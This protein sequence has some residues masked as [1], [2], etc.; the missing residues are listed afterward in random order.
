[1][2]T[3]LSVTLLGVC[4][5]VVTGIIV[6]RDL[7]HARQR[8]DQNQQL[9]HGSVNLESII[10]PDSPFLEDQPLT[11]QPEHA[12]LVDSQQSESFLNLIAD[13][14]STP[15]LPLEPQAPSEL[16]VADDLDPVPLLSPQRR[17]ENAAIITKIMPNISDD[18]LEFWLEE[19]RDLPSEMI[20][21]MLTLRQQFGGLT[22][23]FGSEGPLET[24]QQE[25]LSPPTERVPA[26]DDPILASLQR[27]RNLVSQNNLNYHSIGHLAT[28]LQFV[29][30]YDE[31]VPAGV[32]LAR[33]SLSMEQERYENTGRML[34]IALEPQYFLVV[35]GEVES[36]LTRYGSLKLNDER[37][38]Q[39]A[40]DQ[41]DLFVKGVDPIPE[42]FVMVGIDEQG[43]V[44]ASSKMEGQQKE[45]W[46]E[47]GKLELVTVR[48]PSALKPVG[49]ACYVTTSESGPAS[50]VQAKEEQ[51]LLTAGNLTMS[52][53]DPQEEGWMLDRIN[54]W[55]KHRKE[56]LGSGF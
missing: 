22:E 37:R 46:K 28:K 43:R 9:A 18:Q 27:A 42:E 40:I 1:M 5:L 51:K 45:D 15:A 8:S 44:M 41:V 17:K 49:D 32:R 33:T 4:L 14:D 2:R 23:N 12:L 47:V 13:N 52:N 20:R 38:L 29:E 10:E 24:E 54:A 26:V 7:Q 21:N 53:V 16:P 25:L 31:G 30:A 36:R 50:P 6:W 55:I 34:D 3:R 19:T 35:Q 56:Q 11:G 39:L 48:H